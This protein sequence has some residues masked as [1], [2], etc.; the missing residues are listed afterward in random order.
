MRLF[1]RKG[2]K[3]QVSP[4]GS[5]PNSSNGSLRSPG[6]TPNGSRPTSFPDVPL[7]KAPDPSLDPAGYLRSIYAVRERSRLVLEKAKKNQLK[8]FTV[9]MSKFGDVAS[10]VVSIIKVRLTMSKHAIC[11]HPALTP[12]QRDYAPDYASI[13]PHG[14][15]QHFDVGGRPRIDQLMASW[16][17]TVDNQERTRRLLDLF[18]VSVLLD[19]GAGTKWQYKS[20]E[21]GKVYRRSEGLAVASLE[22]FKAGTFSSDPKEPYQVDSAGLK[23]LDVATVA[24]GLQVTASNP[25]DGLEGRT[26]LLLRLGEALQNQ[27]VFGLEARPGNMLG[28][29]TRDTT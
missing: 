8:H 28:T 12:L 4:A 3:P 29:H 23:K 1:N 26:T 6:P 11:P 19:A 27:E 5:Q 22:M 15:W 18:L 20:K 9:D 2:S 17:S 10:F 24:R 14:R 16:P 7:P 13:P 21:S 25:I